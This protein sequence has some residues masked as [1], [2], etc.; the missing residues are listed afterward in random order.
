[1]DELHEDENQEDDEMISSNHDDE[2][3]MMIAIVVTMTITTTKMSDRL[4]EQ[5]TL[6]MKTMMTMR[7][8]KGNMVQVMKMMSLILIRVIR[9]ID[10]ETDDEIQTQ[11]L[12]RENHEMSRT[13]L[14]QEGVCEEGM[15][16]M[17]VKTE[18]ITTVTDI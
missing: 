2:S 10:H 8:K 17:P 4:D 14:I 1:M 15:N 12:L 18:L 5:M 9:L 7:T 6:K 13:I 3:R 11:V 16:E